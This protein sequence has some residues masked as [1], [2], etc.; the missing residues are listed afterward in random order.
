MKKSFMK[1]CPKFIL[2]TAFA[3]T[4]MLPSQADIMVGPSFPEHEIISA[5]EATPV[6]AQLGGYLQQLNSY[7]QAFMNMDMY[8]LSNKKDREAQKEASKINEH[9][10]IWVSPYGE[11]GTTSVH[12]GP[13]A[14][15]SL[16][17]V[18]VGGESQLKDLGN[19]WE[20]MYGAYMG[21][22]GSRQSHGGT[23]TYQNGGTFGLSG[24][25][26]KNDF[27]AGTT[28]N[29]GAG[30]GRNHTPIND[31]DDFAMLSTGIALKAGY[32]WELA[33]GKFIIQPSLMTSYSYIHPFDYW[34][35]TGL[36]V[37][38]QGIHAIQVEPGLKFIG[39]L[40]NGWQPYAGV[41]LV[42]SIW[43]KTHFR[44]SSPTVGGALPNLSINPYVKYG[45]GLRKVWGDRVAGFVQTY[46]MS[47]G[48]NG[49]GIHGGFR[50]AVGR[51]GSHVI[52]QKADPSFTPKI[53]LNNKK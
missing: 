17:G 22:N 44:M 16:Y 40:K 34:N 3:V 21:Y 29:V 19:G 24:M 14:S 15:T 43:D 51:D 38:A 26:F 41:S 33:D 12:N 46:F 47:G 45:I 6:A 23:T 4:L 27:F 53:S 7:N 42:Y 10:T 20:G 1:N 37:D 50:F 9:G 39:N 30:A 31:Y 11:F 2:A 52:S 8:M 25:V 49:I 48:R 32:N 18:F 13:N 28:V 36:D 5:V 35:S